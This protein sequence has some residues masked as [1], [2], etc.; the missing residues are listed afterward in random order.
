MTEREA[1]LYLAKIWTKAKRCKSGEFEVIVK[2]GGESSLCWGLCTAI[3]HLEWTRDIGGEIA[4]EMN[5]KIVAIGHTDEHPFKWS[6][7]TQAGKL[8]RVK[9]CNDQAKALSAKKKVAKSAS[10]TTCRATSK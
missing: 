7:R 8:A 4:E 6:I 2:K 9:F 1:W 10:A 3:D 5:R